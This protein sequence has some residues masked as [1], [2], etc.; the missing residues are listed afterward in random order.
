MK[1]KDVK[2]AL[3]V[4]SIK[5]MDNKY[6]KNKKAIYLKAGKIKGYGEF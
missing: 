5:D 1:N 6:K 4:V 2:K 3:G